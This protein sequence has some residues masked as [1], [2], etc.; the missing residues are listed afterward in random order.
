MPTYYS[1]AI[2]ESTGIHIHSGLTML[3][4]RSIPESLTNVEFGQ[5]ILEFNMKSKRTE[6]IRLIGRTDRDVRTV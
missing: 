3:I 4:S 6:K 2:S 1:E 5:H